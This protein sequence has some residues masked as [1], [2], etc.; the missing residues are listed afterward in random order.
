MDGVFLFSPGCCY[1]PFFNCF[2]L[3][4]YCFWAE[5]APDIPKS[6][7]TT[8]YLAGFGGREAAAAYRLPSHQI[9]QRRGHR[10]RPPHPCAPSRRS[11]D[12]RL[13][14][15]RILRRG[16]VTAR[17]QLASSARSCRLTRSAVA[18]CTLK[19]RERGG[20]GI[21]GEEREIEERWSSLRGRVGE[22]KS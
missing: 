10:R 20:K 17:C 21:R 18:A 19:E 3:S 6:S 2:L 13:P 16:E 5:L 8:K 22:D 15:R 9:W 7:T 14:S 11:T 1:H 4:A 12:C